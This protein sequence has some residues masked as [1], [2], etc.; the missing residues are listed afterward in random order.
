MI[1]C[2]KNAL[3][4]FDNLEKKTEQGGSQQSP[5]PSRAKVNQNILGEYDHAALHACK[6]ILSIYCS[7]ISD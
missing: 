6:V 3:P 5:P 2:A 7:G 1:K 4:F